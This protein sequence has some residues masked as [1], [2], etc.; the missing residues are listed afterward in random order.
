MV[1][2]STLQAAIL[3]QKAVLS[4][5]KPVFQNFISND[6]S[7]ENAPQFFEITF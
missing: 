3:T 7:A 6:F 5:L 1:N 4:D 2:K